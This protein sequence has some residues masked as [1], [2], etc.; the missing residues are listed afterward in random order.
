MTS[1][2]YEVSGSTATITL[3]NPEKRNAINP[4]MLAGLRSGLAAAEADAAVRAVVLTHTGNTFCAGADLSGQAVG[5]SEASPEE[6]LRESGAQAAEVTRLL[7]ESPRPIIAAIHGHVRAGGMGFVASCDFVV[8]GPRATFG[9]SEVR[10]GV[11]AAI[12]SPPVLARLGDRV[13]AE[14]MLRGGAVSAAEAAAAGFVTRAVG[15]AGAEAGA[16]GA[17]AGAGA[18]AGAGEAAVAEAVGEILAD[19]R[20][21]APGALAASKRLVN[22][23]L[24]ARLDAETD[25]MIE[26]SASGFASAEGQA[27]IQSFLQRTAPPWVLES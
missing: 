18:G 6:R 13:A 2:R 3:D 10:I 19:L 24:L 1:V 8:A 4:E 22:R 12:I 21:A 25:E 5:E 23:A 26:L 14:W 20:K 9:L 15:G 16:A 27:G 17:A 7:A 11:V